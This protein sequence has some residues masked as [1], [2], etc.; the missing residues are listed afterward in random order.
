MARQTK[1]VF[2]FEEFEKAMERAAKRYDKPADAFLIAAARQAAKRARQKSPVVS[3]EL[4]KKWGTQSTKEF[5]GGKV[6]V[7]RVIDRANHA[8]LYENPHKKY[9]AP[10]LEVRGLRRERIDRIS[11][12]QYKKVGYKYHGMS[13]GHYILRDTMK[14]LEE[15][16][17]KKGVNALFEDV[18]GDLEV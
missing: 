1:D 7:S 16:V 8:H 6:K 14:E 17:F 9:T 10:R 4:K 12:R 15:S 11:K 3:G 5:Q 2:G 13:K 18:I